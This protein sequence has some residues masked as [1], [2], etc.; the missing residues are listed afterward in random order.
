MLASLRAAYQ[1]EAIFRPS[2]ASRWMTCPGSVQLIARLPRVPQKSSSYARQGSGAHRL[3]ELVL[4]DPQGL[5]PEDFVGRHI[6]ISDDSTEAVFVDDEM[7]QYIEDYVGIAEAYRN[8]PDTKTFVEHRLTL[9]KLDPANPLF[10]ECRGTGDFVAV[11]QIQRWVLILDL[12]YGLGVPVDGNSKQLRIYLLLA[13]LEFDDGQPWKWG[14]TTVFQ[15]RLPVPPYTEDDHYKAFAFTPDEILGDFAAEV[16]D[17]MYAALQPDPPLVPSKAACRWC[18]AGNVDTC[19]A[20]R[21]AVLRA[22]TEHD[23]Q[24]S[25]MTQ[26]SVASPLT[27][28]PNFVIGNAGV[29]VRPNEVRLRAPDEYTPQELARRLHMGE[30][31]DIWFTGLQHRAAQL[32]AAGIEVPGWYLKPRTGNRRWKDTRQV[33]EQALLQLK[34]K[35][36]DIYTEP[37]LRSPKQ[38]EDRLPKL[39]KGAIDSLVERPPGA[40]TLVHGTNPDKTPRSA[41]LLGPVS[42]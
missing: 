35:P 29:A 41:A 15:P 6:A 40:P 13:M 11:N 23:A 32:I 27:A 38:V 9:Q 37:K 18:E 16:V 12:K 17:A 39:L 36:A 25:V 19:A 21:A 22:A 20:L 4:T 2:N 33:T 10:N 31:L 34:L 42:L 8:T 24:S 7:A 14:G 30:M 3:G 5:S 1:G 26:Y 28:V